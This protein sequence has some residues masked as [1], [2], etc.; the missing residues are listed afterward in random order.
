MRLALFTDTFEPDVNGVA[1][2]LGRWTEY[3]RRQGV[4]VKVFAPDPVGRSE[5]SPSHQVERFI[6][7][8]FFL[9]PECRLALPNPIHLRK[10]LASFK[11]TLIHVATPFNMGLCGIHYAKKHDIPLIASYHTHFDRYLP[12]YNLQWMVK[13][14]WRYMNWFHQDCRKIFVPSRSTLTDLLDKG[15]PAD[16]LEIWSRGMDARS[17]HP[18]VNRKAWLEGHGINADRYLVMYAGR[19]APEKN[20]GIALD[21]FAAF[22]ARTNADAQMVVAGDGPAAEALKER[23]EQEQL[24]VKFLGFL[25]GPEL[26]QW[27]ASADTFLFPSPTE[28]FGNV[29][30]EAMAC[31]A[32]VVVADAGGVTDTVEH[33]VNGVRCPAD[34]PAAFAAAL[35][36]LYYNRTLRLSLAAR[37]RAYS[38]RQSWDSIFAGLLNQCSQVEADGGS[39]VFCHIGK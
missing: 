39:S 23:C 31:G 25:K 13:M 32:P 15:W 37:G 38:L 10:T 3:L 1:R 36:E 7:L 12:F 11:P 35:S 28:T 16:K 29:V 21:A 9:Y 6:S 33:M 24:P 30:L 17:F 20:V 4:Q 19:L 14:L 27:Y 34:Q 5:T 22:Q 2:T 18:N 8:P 26:Q